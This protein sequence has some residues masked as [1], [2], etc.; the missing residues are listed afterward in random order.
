MRAPNRIY[1][2]LTHSLTR[3]TS[4][5][6]RGNARRRGIRVLAT[7]S[8]TVIHTRRELVSYARSSITLYVSVT[9]AEP[10]QRSH[11]AKRG[12]I[13]AH[14]DLGSR[15]QRS[16]HQQW[17]RI[18]PR[19]TEMVLF[20]RSARTTCVRPPPSSPRKPER[21]RIG[22][23]AP[24]DERANFETSQ[25]RPISFNGSRHLLSVVGCN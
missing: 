8:P 10:R 22:P 18:L 15:N 6:V 3:A 4:A 11:A 14:D 7:T 2:S 21:P 19:R 1:H 16:Q 5:S 17:L 12:R 23:S 25:A 24:E 20:R 9:R 13:R